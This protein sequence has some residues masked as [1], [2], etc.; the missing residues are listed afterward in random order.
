MSTTEPTPRE[1]WRDIPAV[2]SVFR[3]D[4]QPE[5]RIA[6]ATTDDERFS[7]PL[8]ETVGSRPLWISVSQNRWGWA[9]TAGSRG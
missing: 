7:I 3:K 4:A 8:S 1:F 9:L 6:D 2:E 5:V